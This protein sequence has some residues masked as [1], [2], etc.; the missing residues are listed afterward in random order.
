DSY[1]I[2]HP[3]PIATSLA[4]PAT[5]P[6]TQAVVH[7]ERESTVLLY[8]VLGLSDFLGVGCALVLALVLLFMVAIMI[9]ARVIGTSY[10]ASAYVWSV[11]L[12]VLL[13]PWQAFLNNANLTAAEFKFPGVLYTWN[14]LVLQ[15]KMTG[16]RKR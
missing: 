4:E 11:V 3:A 16:D 6:A 15:A 7:K 9:V 2:T 8:W 5:Q 12:V 14:E 13:F 1:L 10:A